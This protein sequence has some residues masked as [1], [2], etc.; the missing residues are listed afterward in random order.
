MR[1]EERCATRILG[2]S[3]EK[4]NCVFWFS[5]RKGHGRQGFTAEDTEL[6][7][8]SAEEFFSQSSVSS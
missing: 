4:K 5:Y 3:D 1:D 2:S 6:A 7:E 8:K